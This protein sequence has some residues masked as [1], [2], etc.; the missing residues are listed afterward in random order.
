MFEDIN[1]NSKE[2]IYN[3]YPIDQGENPD[4]QSYDEDV[5][6]V[7][8]NVNNTRYTIDVGWYPAFSPEGSFRIVIV[9][10]CDWENF[11]YNK[12]TR[13][14]K[15]LHKYMEECVE[16]VRRLLKSTEQT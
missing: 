10:N 11:L 1:F 8:Y 16:I 6:Q 12:S 2:Y 13:D 4:Y 14:Y 3:P 5:F 9:K 7:N 15:Q